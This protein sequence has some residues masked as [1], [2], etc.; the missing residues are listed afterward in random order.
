MSNTV[1]S[2]VVYRSN[3]FHA[4]LSTQLLSIVSLFS[5]QLFSIVSIVVAVSIAVVVAIV[6]LAVTT[7]RSRV[8]GAKR[9]WPWHG[10]PR[11]C[12]PATSRAWWPTLPP[13]P[14]CSST[15]NSSSS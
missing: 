2:T 7:P 9:S 4:L 3:G 10:V 6:L 13:L 5:S 14:S 8:R 15:S 11:V 12:S 1:V